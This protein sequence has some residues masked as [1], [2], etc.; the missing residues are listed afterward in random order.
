MALQPQQVQ[1]KPPGSTMTLLGCNF[2]CNIGRAPYSHFVTIYER[3]ARIGWTGAEPVPRI[4]LQI[5]PR[6]CPPERCWPWLPLNLPSALPIPQLNDVYVS[7][8]YCMC[9][10]C[11]GACYHP[12]CR[13]ENF[14]MHPCDSDRRRLHAVK[15]S[16]ADPYPDWLSRRI[17]LVVAITACPG[18]RPTG[19]RLLANHLP[20]SDC[21]RGVASFLILVRKRPICGP[22]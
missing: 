16:R 5:I 11:S 3:Q 15:Q 8:L 19:A 1:Q 12:R 2:S 4:C 18:I 22:C 7:T 21:Y 9:S 13:C 17:F 6:S 20:C 10:G 14:Q